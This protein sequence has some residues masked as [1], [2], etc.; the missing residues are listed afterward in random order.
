MKT[1]LAFDLGAD[2]GWCYLDK[3]ESYTG[4]EFG[5]KAFKATRTEGSPERLINADLFFGEMIQRYRPN[6]VVYERVDFVVSRDQIS[7]YA[8]FSGLLVMRAWGFNQLYTGCPVPTVKKFA[9]PG[10]K[11]RGKEQMIRAAEEWLLRD[12]VNVRFTGD[13]ALSSHEADAIHLARWGLE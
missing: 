12:D 7:L 11:K 6:L 8:Q 5:T 13:K 4:V 10:V 1:V 3:T 2:T 9:L